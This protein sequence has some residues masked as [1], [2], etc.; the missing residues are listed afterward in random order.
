MSTYM[1]PF[2]PFSASLLLSCLP[3]CLSVC[4]SACLPAWLSSY[5]FSLQPVCL[6]VCLSGYPLFFLPSFLRPSA[7]IFLM[8]ENAF[9][10]AWVS[11][12][13][14]DWLFYR[15]SS[16]D[17]QPNRDFKQ[18]LREFPLGKRAIREIKSFALYALLSLIVQAFCFYFTCTLNVTEDSLFS[19]YRSVFQLPFGT[20]R[21]VV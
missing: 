3:V 1:F 16:W 15:L 13:K 9:E 14:H 12:R 6:S 5:H 8:D 18:N 10:P 17:F 20:F 11:T 2:H 4:L 7:R 19:D 21:E